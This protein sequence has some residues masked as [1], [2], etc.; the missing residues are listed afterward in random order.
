MKRNKQIQ[1]KIKR[2]NSETMEYFQTYC[3]K[4]MGNSFIIIIILTMAYSNK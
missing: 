2:E 3:S 1:R 4:P